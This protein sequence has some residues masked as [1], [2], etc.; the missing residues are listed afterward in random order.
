MRSIVRMQPARKVPQPE[1]GRMVL[2]AVRAGSAGSA[3]PRS[4]AAGEMWVVLCHALGLPQ[5]RRL[6]DLSSPVALRALEEPVAQRCA[7]PGRSRVP[8][9]SARP[10]LCWLQ[11]RS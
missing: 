5:E 8:Q 2:P 7:S 6:Q 1:Q 10:R 4:G 11:G 3:L 9:G